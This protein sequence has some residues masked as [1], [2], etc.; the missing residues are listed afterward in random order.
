M[1]VAE[2]VFSPDGRLAGRARRR[3]RAG[4]GVAGLAPPRAAGGGRDRGRLQHRR[5]PAGRVHHAALAGAGLLH[6]R[7]RDP[8]AVQLPRARPRGGAV[9]GRLDHRELRAER[10]GRRRWSSSSGPWAVGVRAAAAG[11][12]VPTRPSPGPPSS[13]ASAS[14]RRPRAAAEERTRIA[15]EL[16]DIVSHSISVVTIQTQAVR[17]RLGP[18]HAAEAADLA[19][20]EA[21]A[22]EALAEM[23]RLFGVLRT[24]GES[25][26]R[27]AP[28]PG[29]AELERLVRQVGSGDLQVGLAGRGRPGP[30]QPGRRPGGVPDRP[31]GPHQRRCATPARREAHVLVRYSPRPAR[32]RGRG[33]RPRAARGGQRHRNGRATA[34]SASASGS[35]STAAPSTSGPRPRAGSGS[36]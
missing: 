10:P 3:R 21:T 13:S 26:A 1:T 7:R 25:A 29:L 31:G 6:R 17:R 2:A 24:E 33:Q 34:W 15:R 23:R 5:Q 11:S 30:A 4:D 22:R 18:D 9:P 27:L 14:S 12:P 32:R 28:Q 20:V 16:H 19:A 35:R 8:P 36:R